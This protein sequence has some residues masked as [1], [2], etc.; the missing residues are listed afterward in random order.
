MSAA[1]AGTLRIPVRPEEKA[2]RGMEG[3]TARLHDAMVRPQ[4]PLP[5]VAERVSVHGNHLD[6]TLTSVTAT[7][8]SKFDSQ[9]VSSTVNNRNP[10]I[11]TGKPYSKGLKIA[12]TILEGL[13]ISKK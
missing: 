12:K 11:L 8:T 4:Q 1:D 13:I 3:E 10:I 6:S 2:G 5:H 9:W 7:G